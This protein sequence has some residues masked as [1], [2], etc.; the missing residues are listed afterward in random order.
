MDMDSE[1]DA[2]DVILR[3]KPNMRWMP[4]GLQHRCYIISGGEGRQ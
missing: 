3:M 2:T 4:K 1:K